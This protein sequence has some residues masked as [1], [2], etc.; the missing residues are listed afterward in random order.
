MLRM[1]EVNEVDQQ[2]MQHMLS[3]GAIDWDGFGDQ[4]AREANA[5]LGGTQSVLLIDESGFAKKGERSAGVSRQWNGRLG[6]VDNC[7][8]GVFAA[9]CRGEMASLVDA[10]L[11][12]PQAW[13][14]DPERCERAAIPEN[15]REYRSKTALALEMVATA[16][17]RGL[18]FGYVGVDG[19][20]GKEPAFL[21]G[22]DALGCR[23]VADVH[24]NRFISRNPPRRCPL[25]RA[26]GAARSTP[27]RSRPRCGS[28]TGRLPNRPTLGNA[29]ACAGVR[30]GS[31]SP[32]TCIPVSG[33]GTT[34]KPRPAAGICSCAGKSAPVT[35][36][37]IACPTPPSTRLGPNWRAT[38]PNG[39]SSS[40]AFARPRANAVW[41]TI[42]CAARIPGIIIWPW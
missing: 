12:L 41:L 30:K 14:D 39:S 31:W 17:R 1:S 37:T 23:F 11:Y 4:L 25:G 6:K 35:S 22:L 20:Y 19:G 9:L 5:L 36:P 15:A 13:A 34:P 38:K 16:Q 21:Y 29:Y 32:S 28:T 24:C 40:T 26:A 8:V 18:R 2:S 7:Q 10:R 33:S 42:R 3:D 27:R